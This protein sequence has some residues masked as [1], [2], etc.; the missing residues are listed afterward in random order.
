M[1]IFG[2]SASLDLAKKIADI[3]SV[4]VFSVDV[5]VFPDG[6]RRVRI[7]EEVLDED[8]VVIQSA[9][10]P[11]DNNYME[12]FFLV[13]ALRRSGAK[14]V[15]A[16]VPYFGYQRQDHVFREGE[17]VSL[18]VVIR[19]LET[20]KVDRLLSVDMHT[21][22]IPD[23]FDI[24]VDHLSALSL[25]A[26]KIKK[27]GWGGEDT[28][29]VSPDMG[30]IARIKKISEFLDNMAYVAIEKNRDLESGSLEVSSLGE[31]NISGQKRGIIVDDM[32]ASGNTIAL[33]AKFLKT[34]GIDE[35][36]V[37]ATHAV[38]SEEAPKILQ[39][40]LVDKVFVTDTVEVEANKKFPKLEIISAAGLIA[41]DL[42]DPMD[43]NDPL[44]SM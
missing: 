16:V 9:C 23:M 13:D 42:K 34:Q 38:F 1:K 28:V 39:E 37:F 18:E 29:L 43:S 33:A 11:V 30:G 8:C 15:T 35:I 12:L 22:K 44:L 14:T 36:F 17:A 4:P 26:E 41:R 25:F 2:G 40:S 27:E 31:G 21:P 19:V 7:V 5:H 6:E 32:I 20:L 10:P 24:P 3:L